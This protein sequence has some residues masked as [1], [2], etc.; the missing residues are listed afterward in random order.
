MHNKAQSG[1]TSF[2]FNVFQKTIYRTFSTINITISDTADESTAQN[3]KQWKNS[4]YL[5]PSEALKDNK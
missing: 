1:L 3:P 4:S 2:L 5:T